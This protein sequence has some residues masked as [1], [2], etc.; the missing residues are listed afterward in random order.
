MHD[1]VLDGLPNEMSALTALRELSVVLESG[2]AEDALW[3]PALTNLHTLQVSRR[4]LLL[5]VGSLDWIEIPFRAIKYW[6]RLL[7]EL[8]SGATVGAMWLPGRTGLHL[9]QESV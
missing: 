8:E 3:L 2:G 9:L 7:M 6:K 5:L 1:A 4:R